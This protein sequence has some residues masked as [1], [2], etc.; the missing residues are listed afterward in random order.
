MHFVI[1]AVEQLD[2]R[3]ARVDEKGS[4][5]EQYPPATMLVLVTQIALRER[6]AGAACGA[7]PAGPPPTAPARRPFTFTVVNL[8]GRAG[9]GRGTGAKGGRAIP[10]SV[11]W[12]VLPLEVARRGGTSP[13]RRCRT[14]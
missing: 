3:S 6:R 12:C 2:L 10:V 5:S 14:A 9:S 4:G 11:V 13:P 8:N 7:E 1:D